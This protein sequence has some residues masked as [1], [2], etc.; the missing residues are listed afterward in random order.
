[1]LF[2]GHLFATLLGRMVYPRFRFAI[3]EAHHSEGGAPPTA[4]HVYGAVYVNERWF[5]LDPTAVYIKDF[6][7]FKNRKSIG[8]DSFNTVDYEHPYMFIPVPL[9]GFERVPYLPE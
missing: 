5:Y 7:D 4:T 1:M 8:V 2:K 6:P 9:S 3:A